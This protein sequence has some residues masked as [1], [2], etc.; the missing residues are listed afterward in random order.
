VKDLR[1]A[2]NQLWQLRV[3]IYETLQEVDKV[4]ERTKKRLGE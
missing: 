1:D 3:S 2:S 4:I